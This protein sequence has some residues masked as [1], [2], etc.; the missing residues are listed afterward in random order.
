MDDRPIVRD[1]HCGFTVV[2]RHCEMRAEVEGIE[3]TEAG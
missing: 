2:P 1:V 3:T